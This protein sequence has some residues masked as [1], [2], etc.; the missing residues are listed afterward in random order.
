MA[1]HNVER[2]FDVSIEERLVIDA[3]TAVMMNFEGDSI[4]DYDELI[5]TLDRFEFRSKQNKLKLYMKN[6]HSL[7]A[8]PSLKRLRNRSLRLYHHF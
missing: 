3:L 6:R 2:G 5:A 8:K 4:E 7:L 1:N